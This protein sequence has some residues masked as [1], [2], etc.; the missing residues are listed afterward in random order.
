[1]PPAT[2]DAQAESLRK[3]ESL[4][5]SASRRALRQQESRK[6]YLAEGVDVNPVLFSPRQF[7]VELY[8]HF[9]YNSLGIITLPL[10]YWAYGK[11]KNLWC[12]KN[13]QFLTTSI[14][15]NVTDTV[16]VVAQVLLYYLYWT[17]RAKIERIITPLMA[18][19]FV[20]LLRLRD[21][22]VAIKYSFVSPESWERRNTQELSPEE[23]SRELLVLGWF[24]I[25]KI[26]FMKEIYASIARTR[27]PVN[28]SVR[29]TFDGVEILPDGSEAK[30]CVFDAV[31]KLGCK[32][33]KNV[34]WVY[35]EVI[36]HFH[37][38]ERKHKVEVAE[39]WRKNR[40]QTQ[41][42]VTGEALDHCVRTQLI[43]LELARQN[44]GRAFASFMGIAFC[45][46]FAPL[47]LKIATGTLPI[48]AITP[49]YIVLLSMMC[50]AGWTSDTP[51]SV[52]R[53]PS[54]L[55][56]PNRAEVSVHIAT[57]T[58]LPQ[59]KESPP[60]Y[61]TASEEEQSAQLLQKRNRVP[62]CFRRGTECP[63][64]SEEEQSARLLQKRNR[65]PDCF[66]RGTECPTASEEEQSARLLQKRNRVP[67]CFRRGTECPTA[68]EEEQSARLLQKR[69]RVPDCFRRGTECPTASEEEQSARLLPHLFGMFR[70]AVLT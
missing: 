18:V 70:V 36:P 20:T 38:D 65:V 11:H 41:S 27:F 58:R 25:S 67:D 9:L 33:N 28:A 39:L 21:V 44:V 55:D 30:E 23:F 48:S 45:I 32:S 26:S 43:K 49:I 12:L 6:T 69:N 7:L 54:Y 51:A 29:L 53:S 10:L 17:E 31:K 60:R 46:Y 3:A 40:C 1:M 61:P 66:R 56:N 22:V 68:A 5:R 62:D 16:Q 19:F 35:D 57:H 8:T 52:V 63:T 47:F 64:A 50:M 4:K 59:S 13:R 42:G 24:R 14:F 2:E 15:R 34:E 37:N